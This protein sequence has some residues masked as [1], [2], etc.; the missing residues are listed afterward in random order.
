MT[1]T[2]SRPDEA[3]PARVDAPDSPDAP[4]APALVQVIGARRSGR[5]TRPQVPRGLRRLS[6][7]LGLVVLWFV[8]SSLGILKPQMFP[9]PPEVARAGWDLVV[10]G[11][12]P[13]HLWASLQ[14]V[15]I[16][17]AI[18]VSA[19]VV[20]ATAAGLTRRMED[21]VDST[22]QVLKAIPNFSLIPLLIIWMGIDEAPKITLVALATLMPIYI[23]T[24]GAIRNVDAKLVE[25]AGTLGLRR[26]GLVRHVV[27]PGAVP[28]F[29]VGLRIAF[30]SAWLALIFAESLNAKQGLGK[31][32]S[33]GRS[34]FR[35]DIMVFVI[36]IYA[37]L[38]LLSYSIVR[39]LERRLLSWRRGFEGS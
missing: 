22:M 26:T 36:V 31:L 16:G 4:A 20:L 30:T 12:V 33:D 1:A 8:L 23:N 11:E 2:T 17:L 7:P 25:V 27:L 29:L 24:Y 9:T 14:R 5:A 34:W 18:G 6:G 15:L 37:V 19:G 21:V 39:L 3:A 38:G 10:S 35:V 32:M 28:G 13:R